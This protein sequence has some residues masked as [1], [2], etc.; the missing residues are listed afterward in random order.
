MIRMRESFEQYPCKTVIADLLTRNGESTSN[1]YSPYKG[2]SYLID[3]QFKGIAKEKFNLEEFL[4]YASDMDLDP[5]RINVKETVTDGIIEDK[6]NAGFTTLESIQGQEVYVAEYLT[7]VLIGYKINSGSPYRQAGFVKYHYD[8]V[9]EDDDLTSEVE[10][11]TKE[12]TYDIEVYEEALAEIPYLIKTIFNYGK[13]IN[14]NM[15]SFLIAYA[16]ITKTKLPEQIAPLDFASYTTIRIKSNGEF[17]HVFN[18]VQDNKGEYYKAAVKFFR[19]PNK[20]DPTYKACMKLIEDFKMV[21]LDIA[22]ENPYEYSVDFV[23]SMICTYLPTNDEYISNYAGIDAELAQALKPENLFAKRRVA[24]RTSF[25]DSTPISMEGM[26][27]CIQVYLETLRTTE[28]ERFIR[29]WVYEPNTAL[30]YTHSLVEFL[31]GTESADATIKGLY[32]H[33]GSTC[34][35]GKYA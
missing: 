22:K 7:R 20:L 24:T 3:E 18:H 21:G 12:D 6:H 32:I 4:D 28:P 26:V 30:E 15:M 29:D 23:N 9:D 17:D 25:Y 1:S 34:E 33:T 8:V 2:M 10:F 14:C 16:N 35:N 5:K 31:V 13:Q 11:R 19:D 27:E